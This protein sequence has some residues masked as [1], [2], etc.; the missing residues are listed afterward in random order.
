M[1]QIMSMNYLSS[2]MMLVWFL[3]TLLLLKNLQLTIPLSIFTSDT[4]LAELKLS[5]FHAV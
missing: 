2:K 3:E 1:L 4:K 5:Q